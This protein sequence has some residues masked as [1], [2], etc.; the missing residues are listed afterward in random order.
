MT[1]SSDRWLYRAEDGTEYGPFS[2]LQIRAY[3]KQNRITI[4]G[5]LKLCDSTSNWV[6]YADALELYP[7]AQEILPGHPSADVPA[8]RR[9]PPEILQEYS[10]TSK[11]VYA[12]F[13]I[14][15]GMC[16]GFY[17]I[18]NLTAEYVRRGAIQLGLS[19]FGIW[20]CCISSFFIDFPYTT[21]MSV[22]IW[23]SLAF[24]V[25]F[26]VMTVQKDGEGRPFKVSGH[27]G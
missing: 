22:V 4:A 27:R 14:L 5:S 19:I 10:R 25:A 24:W 16:F 1:D 8:T 23:M 9:V 17:G 26:E 15:F 21:C 2:A 18:H 11:G 20:G 13:G 12:T 3:I 6:S 7:F